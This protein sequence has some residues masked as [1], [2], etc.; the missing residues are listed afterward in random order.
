MEHLRRVWDED[1]SFCRDIWAEKYRFTPLGGESAELHPLDTIQRVVDGVYACDPG[2]AANARAFQAI[3]SRRFIPGGR[4]LADAGTPKH[5]TGMNCYVMDTLPDDL[6]GIFRV[7]GESA[8]TMQQGGGIGVDFSSLRPKGA[9]LVRT[10]SDA[11]G[12]IT[13]MDAWDAMCRTIMSAGHRRG[14]M[15]ATLRCD[16]PDVRTFVHAKQEKG[17][18]TNF[19]VSV[20]AT[21]AFMA[22]IEADAPWQLG[23]G[24][25][26]FDGRHVGVE[27]RDGQAWYVYER[28]PARQLW[29]EILRATYEAAEPGVIFIDRINATNN[30]SYCETIHSTNP[31]GEQPLPPYGA[32]NLGAINLAVMVNDPW[33]DN[34]HVAMKAVEETART[35]M[36]FLDNVLDTTGYPLAQQEAEAK[37]KRRT[38]LGV[39]GLANM[40]QQLQLPYGTEKARFVVACVMETIRNAAYD[41]SAT[42]AAERGPFPLFDRDAYLKRPFVTALPLEVRENIDRCGIRNG[43]LLTVAPTGTTAIFAGNVSSGIEPVF[44]HRYTRKVRQPDDGWK[45]ESVMDWGWREY[46]RHLDLDP[47]TA[48][49]KDLPAYMWTATQLGVDDHVA[50]QATVQKFID[51]SISKTINCPVDLSFEWFKAVY[52]LAWKSGCKGCT[53]YRPSAARGAVL[54]AEQVAP[55]PAVAETTAVVSPDVWQRPRVMP[56]RTYKIK[57]AEH[58]LYVTITD[59]A[60]GRPG[61]LFITTKDASVQEWTQLTGRLLS[62]IMRQ[63][64]DVGFLADEMQQVHAGRGG[65]WEHGVYRPSI[66]AAIGAVLAEHIGADVPL[67]VGMPL[68]VKPSPGT[69]ME[70][71]PRCQRQALVRQDGCSTC[72]E[73][74]WSNCA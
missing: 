64:I 13:F 44:A 58:A 66:P 51:A 6:A 73:C 1:Q 19:N 5:T 71:C 72:R 32:C 4:I 47:R 54:E 43:V 25:P 18:L 48:D 39:M 33:T 53:T 50:M 17:R 26:R 49:L 70:A 2:K 12:P 60:D 36:R 15:M 57:P 7:L 41:A 37:N 59:R 42:L 31:C 56:G 55:A 61:E 62:A 65:F 28:L 10:H 52:D 69:M 21:D 20:L 27:E 8:L 63:G 45:S 14:A 22:A 9:A 40:L 67:M 34:A 24:K 68:I 3:A 30:L 38:G 23:F 74:G 35:A 11:S 16:H 46:C 29:D